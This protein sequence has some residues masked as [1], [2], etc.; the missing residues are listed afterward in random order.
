MDRIL[1][2]YGR[3]GNTKFLSPME[4]EIHK[5]QNPLVTKTSLKGVFVLQEES[6]VE[7]KV[8]LIFHITPFSSFDGMSFSHKKGEKMNLSSLKEMTSISHLRGR[9]NA[10]LPSLPLKRKSA[11]DRNPI[12][13]Q[14]A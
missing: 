2:S 4:I 7:R 13:A 11:K 3:C 14:T 6:V 12:T 10:R 8:I 9:R 1:V 5:E